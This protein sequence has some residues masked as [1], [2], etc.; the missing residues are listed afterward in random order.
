MNAEERQRQS[1]IQKG[2]RPRNPQIQH[3]ILKAAADLVLESGFRALSMD[4]IAGR[5]GVG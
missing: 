2:G 3:A 1:I 4:A 5:A